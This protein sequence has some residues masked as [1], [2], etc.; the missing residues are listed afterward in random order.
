LLPVSKHPF[1]EGNHFAKCLIFTNIEPYQREGNDFLKQIKQIIKK[2][3]FACHCYVHPMQDVQ[4]PSSQGV[5]LS[6]FTQRSRFDLIDAYRPPKNKAS[7]PRALSW[8]WSPITALRYSPRLILFPKPS[9]LTVVENPTSNK[10]VITFDYLR[11]ALT[12][13]P[14]IA[15]SIVSSVDLVDDALQITTHKIAGLDVY[16]WEKQESPA[17]ELLLL[18]VKKS[19]TEE[20]V[21]FTRAHNL[22]VDFTTRVSKYMP[23]PH[24]S[25]IYFT[26]LKALNAFYTYI[27]IPKEASPIF[28]EL[29]VHILPW[30][31]DDQTTLPNFPSH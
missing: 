8:G 30:I 17:R 15:D 1:K 28:T 6:F 21:Y 3:G 25:K 7:L 19:A 13:G 16:P 4:N 18:G 9:S 29:G 11:R 24:S 10:L 22:S 26:S 27:Y 20:L 5:D 2:S 12:R 31:P 23:N 14:L